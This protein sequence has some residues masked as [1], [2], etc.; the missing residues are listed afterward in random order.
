MVVEK[1]IADAIAKISGYKTII[2]TVYADTYSN[3]IYEIGITYI[4][5][6][7]PTMESSVSMVESQA[8][9]ASVAQYH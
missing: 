4:R 1:A 5:N 2:G 9:V 6:L 8:D 7:V 3:L